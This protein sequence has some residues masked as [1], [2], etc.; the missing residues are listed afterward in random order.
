MRSAASLPSRRTGPATPAAPASPTRVA[1]PIVTGNAH[2]T[3]DVEMEGML[4]LKVLRSP[5]A[6]ARITAIRKD[7]A[8][9]VPGVH[10][11]FTWED[12]PRRPFTTACH[13]DFRV[14]PDD[15][16]MLDNV[17]RFVGQRVAAVVA[18]TEA[19]RRRAAGCVEVDYEVLP[20]VFDP[21]EAML[22]GAPQIHGD[23]DVDSRIEEFAHNVF[24][25]I[26][27]ET[28]DVAGGFA[29]ADAVYEGTFDAAEDPACAHGNP[30]HDRLAHRRRPHPRP[31]QH[32]G[33]SP[34]EDQTRLPVR[35]VSAPGSTCFPNTS[36]AGSAASRKCSPKTCACWRRS[37]TGRPV[38]WEF[39]RSEA[40][41]R[42]DLPPSDEN[43][44]QAGREAGRHAHRDADPHRLQHG[45]LRQ[46]RR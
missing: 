6:H 33:P 42:G 27:A 43:H 21:E 28:G 35:D 46:P 38:K 31:H 17:A 36:A 40:I 3:M 15:T 23:K 41:H 30:R 8:L 34:R 20:A 39:T 24:K 25:K 45:S 11:V 10:A 29:E 44:D 1:E 7:K 13:D 26:E 5:H 32:P 12:V 4:H 19:P 9:A 37:K 14:D 16:Y 22:P 2:Y 18:E